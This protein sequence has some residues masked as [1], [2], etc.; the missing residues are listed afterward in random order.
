[1][2]IFDLCYTVFQYI[3]VN[4]VLLNKHYYSSYKVVTNPHRILTIFFLSKIFH[5][6]SQTIHYIELFQSVSEI[7]SLL[8]YSLSLVS[9]S[10]QAALPGERNEIQ[11]HHFL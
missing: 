10:L 3:A 7:F 4:K 11:D 6:N 8:T 2:C 5:M 1:M 9:L